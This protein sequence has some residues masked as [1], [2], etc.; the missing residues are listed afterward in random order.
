M[1]LSLT[2]ESAFL[3]HVL[4]LFGGRVGSAVISFLFAFIVARLFDPVDFGVSALFISIVVVLAPVVS[5]RFDHAII[6][7]KLELESTKLVE[8]SLLIQFVFFLVLEL[9][10]IAAIWYFYSSEWVISMGGWLYALPVAVFVVGLSNVCSSIIT[11]NKEFKQLAAADMIEASATGGTRVVFGL[12]TGT[13][14]SGLISGY[15]GGAILK[16]IWLLSKI[17]HNFFKI[18][19]D[20]KGLLRVFKEYKEFPMHSAP[21]GLL[22]SV[23]HN[24][25]VLM[26]S[27][28]F[29]PA[30]TGFFALG[31][32]FVSMPVLMIG[33][34]VRRV[35]LQQ[36]ANDVNND[37]AIKHKLIN[38]TLQL[39]L[40]SCL[41]F[42]PLFLFGK[43]LFILFFGNKWSVAGEYMSILSPWFFSALIQ[44]P[45]SAIYPVFKKQVYLLRLQ[46]LVVLSAFILFYLS[47]INSFNVE[48]VLI[49]FTAISTLSNGF[50]MVEAFRIVHQNDEQLTKAGIK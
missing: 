40:I 10:V 9:C 2:N 44:A 31:N 30:V 26:L 3:R 6:L 46:L 8:L 1:S 7:P 19:T 18:N 48:S 25:P 22:R 42:I 13:S 43:E 41:I 32:R 20:L 15:I 34:S 23:Y 47:K 11:R 28:L 5:L 29:D 36:C 45:S 12:L 27:V 4:T 33:D 35:F 17:K 14:V 50:I 21:T 49:I 37:N 16:L 24:F 38:S 39:L